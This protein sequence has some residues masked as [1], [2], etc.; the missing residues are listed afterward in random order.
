MKTRIKL[1]ID[2]SRN[3]SNEIR[4]KIFNQGYFQCCLFDF[5]LEKYSI[6]IEQVSNLLNVTITTED[7]SEGIYHLI[8][9]IIVFNFLLS[10]KAGKII[11]PISVYTNESIDT[12]ENELHFNNF[13]LSGD[14]HFSFTTIE[15]KKYSHHFRNF[16]T[17]YKDTTYHQLRILYSTQYK[18]PQFINQIVSSIINAFEGF[19]KSSGAKFD[20]K[21]RRSVRKLLSSYIN[22]DDFT[23]RLS[24]LNLSHNIE[25][26][27]SK[28]LES[29]SRFG[30]LSLSE[31]FNEIGCKHDEVRIYLD[32]ISLNKSFWKTAANHRNYLA[33]LS[34]PKNSHCF[35]S[36]IENLFALYV[37]TDVF[38]IICLKQIGVPVDEQKINENSLRLNAWIHSGHYEEVKWYIGDCNK[39]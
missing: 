33:H 9:S 27:K 16:Y 12:I 32:K 1:T 17:T 21:T 14:E 28:L 30:E 31:V 20:R 7:Y 18:S 6:E 22:S 3:N 8:E 29:L 13:D 10:G 2:Y 37:L 26:I 23:S 35:D 5:D 38:R 25:Y 39:K 19:V 4:F 11:E 36:A 24:V 15:P 34:E